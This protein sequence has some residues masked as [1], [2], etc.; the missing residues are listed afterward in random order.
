MKKYFIVFSTLFLS[1]CNGFGSLTEIGSPPSLTRT[2]DPTRD[3]SYRPVTMPMPPLQPPPSEAAS[4]W[5]PG[6]RAFFKDQRASQ[7]GDLI[8]V[9]VDIT[10]NATIVD[11]T[12]ATG[13][14]TEAM[15]MPSLFGFQSKAISHLTSSSALSTSSSSGNTATGRIGRSETVTIR[16]AGTITQVLPN[17]NFVVV[18]RQ[19]VRINSELRELLV[20]GVARPQDITADNTVT[21]DR[22]AEARISYGGRGQLSILQTPRYGQQLLNA[23]APF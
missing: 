19:E 20:T 6:S 9:I 12:S 18:A 16:L 5:R 1:G 13:S 17:G 14:G 22:L 15:G 2:Q 21:H 3:T 4:L 8:T 11:N 23:V 7:V 10:D